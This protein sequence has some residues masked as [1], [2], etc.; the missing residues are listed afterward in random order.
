MRIVAIEGV[1]AQRWFGRTKAK[2]LYSLLVENQPT[3]SPMVNKHANCRTVFD[4]HSAPVFEMSIG[5]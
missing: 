2:R 1:P 5:G 4:S 3:R